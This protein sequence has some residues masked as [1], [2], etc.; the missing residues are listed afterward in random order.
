MITRNPLPV[1]V[2]FVDKGRVVTWGALPILHSLTHTHPWYRCFSTP[3][4]TGRV[5]YYYYYYYFYDT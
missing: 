4:T 1:V 2:V 3:F 5:Y